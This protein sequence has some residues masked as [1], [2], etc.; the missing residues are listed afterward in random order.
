MRLQLMVGGVVAS[1]IGVACLAQPPYYG[2]DYHASTA[3][4][5][6]GYG[7]ASVIRAQ[8]ANNYMN[9]EAAINLTQAQSQAIQNNNA[10]VQNY[11]AKKQMN[12][13]YNEAQRSGR[14]HTDLVKLA[15]DASPSR[16]QSSQLNPVTGQIYWPVA[17]RTNGFA[18][19]RSKLDQVFA[20]RAKDGVISDLGAMM[21]AQK[22]SEA[23]SKTLNSQIAAL[24]PAIYSESHNFLTSL[25]KEARL[26][27]R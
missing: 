25:T 1:L 9:S 21:D 22:A 13:A 2:G 3:A 14:Y 5:G 19:D 11:Y 16:L 27:A 20:A 10:A 23:M 18:A 7:M 6:A 4:E 24:P 8:G 26:P 15:A 12:A 17:L